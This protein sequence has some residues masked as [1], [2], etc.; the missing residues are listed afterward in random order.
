MAACGGGQPAMVQ[1]A[2][3]SHNGGAPVGA[4]T[5]PDHRSNVQGPPHS[6][7][8]TPTR[9]FHALRFNI[10][11][12][13]SARAYFTTDERFSEPLL[14]IQ[15]LPDC[16]AGCNILVTVFKARE[17]VGLD[18]VVRLMTAPAPGDGGRSKAH[19]IDTTTVGGHLTIRVAFDCQ[20]CSEISFVTERHGWIAQ[21]ETKVCT[22]D[23]AL[24]PMLENIV[25]SFRWSDPPPAPPRGR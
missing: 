20:G 2:P 17:H 22:C 13:S 8:W 12:P 1:V 5:A 10:E 6:G 9:V 7:S 24:A 18:S 4:R 15:D 3:A 21:I 16:T 11:Y 19:V 14:W 23:S 25:R